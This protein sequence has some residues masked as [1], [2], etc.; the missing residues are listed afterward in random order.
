MKIRLKMYLLMFTLYCF[1]NFLSL[2]F[3]NDILSN[4]LQTKDFQKDKLVVADNSNVYTGLYQ[5]NW[6]V[7]DLMTLIAVIECKYG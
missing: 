1:P 5:I 6:L 7:Y 2:A 4:K 3:I